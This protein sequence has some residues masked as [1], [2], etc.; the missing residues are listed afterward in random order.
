M[1]VR[2]RKLFEYLSA[3]PY[4]VPEKRLYLLRMRSKSKTSMKVRKSTCYQSSDE[5]SLEI[6]RF[7]LRLLFQVQV[8]CVR[9]VLILPVREFFINTLERERVLIS[10]L[11]QVDEKTS[12]LTNCKILK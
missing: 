4:L 9:Q 11:P 10:L 1:F 7:S 12:K 5:S 6:C 3:S 8:G 2:V